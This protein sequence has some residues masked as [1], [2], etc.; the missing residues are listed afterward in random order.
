MDQAELDRWHME[1]ALELAERGRGYVEPNPMVG[2]IVARGA[3]VLAEGWHRRFGGP[4]AEVEALQMAGSRARGATLYVTLEPCCHYGKTPPCTQAILAAGIRRVVVALQDPFP[5]VAGKGLQELRQAGVEV[6]CGVLEEQAAELLAAYRKRLSRGRPWVLAKWAMTLDGKVA[7]TAGKSRWISSEPARQVVH[8]LRGLVDAVVVGIGTVLADDPLLTARP[9]GPRVPVR[10]VL[11]GAA[12]LPLDSQLV[13]TAREVPVLVVVGPQ[14][15]SE[16]I[17]S[18]EQAGCEVLRINAADRVDRVHALLEELGRRQ[19]TNLL[20][21]GGPTVLGSF[22]GAQEV[23]EVHVFVAAKIFG[24]QAAPSA[25]AGAG[26]C[27]PEQ[28]WQL[29]KPQMLPMEPDVYICGR[30]KREVAVTS[31][32]AEDAADSPETASVAE[33]FCADR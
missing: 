7:T 28:A 22:F 8:R 9:P 12:R 23:D 17:A 15:S 30:V 24:G 6:L 14:A 29:A 31:P 32:A 5:A 25:V 33:N 10:I 18:L 11:D 19:M 2:C 1:R 27:L 20:V 26:V 21:E 3:E 4:H 13:R 16:A